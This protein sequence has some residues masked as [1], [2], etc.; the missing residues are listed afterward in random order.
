M[1]KVKEK[2]KYKYLNVSCSLDFR[3]KITKF[4]KERCLCYSSMTRQLWDKY[5]AEV[6]EREEKLKS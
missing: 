5:I 6:K 1:A 3:D 2:P 4:C